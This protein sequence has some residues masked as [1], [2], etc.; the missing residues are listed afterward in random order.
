MPRRP[1]VLALAASTLLLT[2]ADRPRPPP[3]EAPPPRPTQLEPA[4]EEARPVR[5]CRVDART[6]IDWEGDFPGVDLKARCKALKGTW[7]D[8]ACPTEKQVGTCTVREMSSRDR[9]VT[10]AYPPVSAADARTACLKE[11]RASFM[12]R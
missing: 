4:P 1:L 8:G 12:K 11:P 2:A 7:G 10:H 6:C 3:M 5:S 9:S